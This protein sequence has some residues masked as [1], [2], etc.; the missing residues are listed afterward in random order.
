[1]QCPRCGENTPG[2]LSGCARCGA[3]VDQRPDQQVPQGPQAGGAGQALD[4]T[5]LDPL[6]APL[7]APPAIAP[8]PPAPWATEMTRV[9]P[10][11][12]ANFMGL[13]AGPGGPGTPPSPSAPPA[14]DPEATQAWTLPPEDDEPGPPAPSAPAIPATPAT[15]AGPQGAGMPEPPPVPSWAGGTPEPPGGPIVPDSWFAEPRPPSAEPSVDQTRVAMPEA[16]GTGV[17]VWTPGGAAADP[18]WGQPMPPQAL[19]DGVAGG[20]FNGQAADAGWQMQPGLPGPQNG[21]HPGTEG[22]PQPNAGYPG[23]DGAYPAPGVAYPGPDGA[24]PAP[25]GGYPGPDGAYPAPGGAYPDPNGA[26]PDPNGAYPDPNGAYPGPDG[27][28]PGPDG[29]YGRQRTGGRSNKPLAIVVGVLVTVAVVAVGIVMWPNGGDGSAATASSSAT[30]SNAAQKKPVKKPPSGPARQQAQVVN[31]LL[32]ASA[33]TRNQLGRALNAA[34]RCKDLPTAIAGFQRVAKRRTNQINRT[35]ALKVDALRNGE[36]LRASLLRSFQLSLQT[37]QAFLAWAQSAQGCKGR[38]RQDANYARGNSLSTQATLA[39][40][41]F[42]VLWNPVARD[43][44]LPA[45]T[46]SQF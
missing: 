15:P 46:D 29:G 19:P 9:E 34:A 17:E 1:M 39:K 43:V 18:A 13:P 3:P 35:N 16:P 12:G 7:P 11:G 36:R 31:E 33:A 22:Y 40:R 26:Y 28:Y 24:Y 4:A 23:P 37:D 8:A 32:D 14:A 21:G 2:T 25:G 45:R 44:G 27:A 42:T 41:Q 6:H 30:P 10:L 20:G 38:P 5:M